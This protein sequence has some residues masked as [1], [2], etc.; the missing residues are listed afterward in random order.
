[1]TNILYDQNEADA[2]SHS[3]QTEKWRE[4]TDR[5][6]AQMVLD[7]KGQAESLCDIGCAWGQ[8]L[9]H[10]VGEFDNLYGVDESKDRL[11]ALLNN[12]DG[13]QVYQANS[14]LLP[15][16]DKEVDI[17]LMSHILHEIKLFSAEG[18]FES[19]MQEVRRVLTDRGRFMVI[20]H[21]DPGDGERSIRLN[22]LMLEKFM[23]FKENFAYR[24]VEAEIKG[25][26]VT[27]SLRDCHDFITK[28][29]S[30][31]SG[32]EKLEMEETHTVINDDEVTADLASCGFHVAKCESFNC[33]S[34]LMG[35]YGIELVN[36]NL[37][38][39]QVLVV[40]DK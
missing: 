3:E 22:R 14:G 8:L 27:M 30:L 28:I 40:A 34:N 26:V 10:F 37:W 4:E 9:Q 20:D 31:G 17:V 32:A 18:I 29:W 38:N 23:H 1:M 6:K 24:K 7:N 33:I 15:L 11:G 39:R 36:G 35:N 25:D 16:P 12:K 5:L 13:I 2:L 21:R 19:T